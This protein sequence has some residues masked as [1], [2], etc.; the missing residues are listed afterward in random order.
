LSL[1]TYANGN[2]SKYKFEII[3]PYNSEIAML[4]SRLMGY[5]FICTVVIPVFPGKL[6]AVNQKERGF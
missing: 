6:G 5:I 1:I 3:V 4:N 2:T